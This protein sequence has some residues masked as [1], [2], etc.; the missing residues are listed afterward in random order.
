MF[1]CNYLTCSWGD[2]NAV[3]MVSAPNSWD[4]TPITMMKSIHSQLERHFQVPSTHPLGRRGTPKRR[5]SPGQNTARCHWD[6]SWGKIN[7]N[8]AQKKTQVWLSNNGSEAIVNHLHFFRWYTP[9]VC[10]VYCC[11]TDCLSNNVEHDVVNHAKTGGSL[12]KR[13]YLH[14]SSNKYCGI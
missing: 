4:I 14:D 13:W 3:I 12:S 5:R 8:L 7:G 10:V 6:G 9:S 11:C 1:A 2:K